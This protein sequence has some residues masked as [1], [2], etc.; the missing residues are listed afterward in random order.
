MS[1]WLHDSRT[2][3]FSNDSDCAWVRAELSDGERSICFSSSRYTELG[4]DL[5]RL[6]AGWL[7]RQA[8]RID[9][10]SAIAKPA[11]SVA[12]GTVAE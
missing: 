8:D 9:G 12:K 7:N 2:I 1:L 11:E 6:L 4:P 10:R 3:A 5:C